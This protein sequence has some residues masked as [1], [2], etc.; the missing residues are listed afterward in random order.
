ML[1][2]FRGPFRVRFLLVVILIMFMVAIVSGTAGAI[3]EDSLRPKIGLALGGGGAL[4]FAH[5]GVLRWLEEHRIPVDYIAGTSMGGLIGACY[6]MGMTPDEISYLI[7]GIN[8]DRMFN[9]DPPYDSLD[10]RRKEDRRDYPILPEIGLRGFQVKLPDGL[11]VHE[12]GMLLSRITLPYS[13]I[14]SFDELPIPYR[15]VAVDIRSSQVVILEDGLL[16]EAMRATMAIPGVFTPVER[17][18]RLLVDGGILKNLPVDVVKEM[19]ASITVG[20][21]LSSSKDRQEITGLNNILKYTLN[22]ITL[23]N[24]NRAAEAAD[25]IIAPVSKGLTMTDWEAVLEFTE[26]GY[27]AAAEQ[28]DHL[29]AYSMDESSWQEYLNERQMKRRLIVP[30]PTGIEVIG[31]S[32]INQK[33]IKEKLASHVNRS[34]DPDQLEQDLRDLV[35]SGLY[36]GF[37]YGLKYNAFG[38]PVLLITAIEKAY[39]PPFVNT[40]FLLDADGYQAEHVNINARCRITWHNIAGPGSELRTDLGFGTELQYLGEIYKPIFRSKW[41]VAPAV[42][43]EQKNSSLFEAEKRINHYK[44]INKGFRLDLGYGFN[45][46]CEARLGWESYQQDVRVGVEADLPGD[47][48]GE[49]RLARLKYTYTSADGAMIDNKGLFWELNVKRYWKG[50]GIPESF[51]QMETELI[52]TQPFPS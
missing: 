32:A 20:V 42:F 8:W 9:P 14:E 44:V 45:K 50:P 11:P 18:G 12:I 10:F 31:T 52:W 37:R 34:V 7:S 24:S 13:T 4:G 40:A 41:F 15:C 22:T 1:S 36:E 16:A 26:N 39:G 51:T 43:F 5:I 6:A 19:G 2:R 25:I 38:K 28:A 3:T 30:K 17:Q 46:R 29:K 35:G 47:N 23:D 48:D 33:L 49:V 21:Q 27:R